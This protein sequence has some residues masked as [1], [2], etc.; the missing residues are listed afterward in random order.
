MVGL[1]PWLAQAA[2]HFR[3]NTSAAMQAKLNFLLTATSFMTFNV[4]TVPIDCLSSS[5]TLEHLVSCL[6][7]YTVQDSFYTAATYASAQPTAAQAAAWSSAVSSLMNVGNGGYTCADASTT[8]S[9]G[10]ALDGI[11]QIASFRDDVT[12][13]SYCM[14]VESTVNDAGS[15]AKGWG[16][17][18]VPVTHA[19]SSGVHLSAPHPVHDSGTA[20]QASALFKSIS[21]RSL[22]VSGRSRAAYAASTTCVVPSKGSY[23]KT[24]SA[25]DNEQPFLAASVALFNAQMVEGG[26]PTTTCAFVQLHGKA[27]TT[28]SKDSMFMSAGIGE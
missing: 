26:C 19:A 21:A 13:A 22:L 17:V 7:V 6:D 24:D 23:Y 25:H 15:Y 1:L 2:N 18:I 12:L 5:A 14:L 11:Y 9:A 8:I 4:A 20:K 28:C 27:N 3:L 16:F 10:N